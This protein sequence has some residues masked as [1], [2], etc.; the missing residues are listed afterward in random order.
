MNLLNLV[1]VSIALAGSNVKGTYEV[2]VTEELKPYAVY[3]LEKLQLKEADDGQV[4]VSYSL[5]LEL[6]GVEN[7]IRF[8]GK[9][10]ADGSGQ[11]EGPSGGMTCL[12]GANGAEP[13]CRVSY[14]AVRQD[15]DLVRAALAKFPAEEQAPRLQVA[16]AFGG[17]LEGFIRFQK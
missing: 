9:F 15:L 13:I 12:A 10:A 11:F 3:S 4:R 5:P 14:Y 7:K 17:D 1:L 16:R 8:Y 2:P 6:T